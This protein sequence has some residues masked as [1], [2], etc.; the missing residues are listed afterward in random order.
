MM[1]SNMTIVDCNPMSGYADEQGVIH[2]GSIGRECEDLYLMSLC[3]HAII[4]NSTFSWWA[5]WLHKNQNNRLVVAP[6]N[7]FHPDNKKLDAT[8]IVPARWTRI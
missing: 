1:A 7:W 5:A 4:A 6:K 8:D 3:R 2:K